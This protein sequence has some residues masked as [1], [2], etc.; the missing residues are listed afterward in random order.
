MSVFDGIVVGN[1]IASHVTLYYLSL[2]LLCL[3]NKNSLPKRLLIL[4]SPVNKPCSLYS[5]CHAGTI[6]ARDGISP[7]GD[8]I[9]QSYVKLCEFVKEKNPLG[10]YE[11]SL[12]K[13]YDISDEVRPELSKEKLNLPLESDNI[14][15]GHQA[16]H[17]FF[18][19]QIFLDWTKSEYIKNFNNLNITVNYKKAHITNI[20]LDGENYNLTSGVD[21]FKASS[22]LLTS[23]AELFSIWTKEGW[24][25]PKLTPREGDYLL[26]KNIDLGDESFSIMIVSTNVIYRHFRKELLIGGTTNMPNEY[27]DK[28]NNKE[29]RF[30]HSEFKHFYPTLPDYDKFEIKRGA[31][32]RGPKRYPYCGELNKG[33]FAMVGL[34]KNGF[35]FPFLMAPPLVEEMI[36][37]NF[38]K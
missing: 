2:R 21:Q 19:P 17:H 36:Q 38:L 35:T 22:I 32:V 16:N 7:L 24:N 20:I 3:E 37:K 12:Y 4:E 30:Y 29:L 34:Y 9:K 26:L 31:R 18:D 15:Y 14:F 23:G 13:S 11:G 8:M 10:V 5:T 28:P 25:H 27:L 33:L 1:G 6:N